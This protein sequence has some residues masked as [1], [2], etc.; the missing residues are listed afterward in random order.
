MCLRKTNFPDIYWKTNAVNRDRGQI[1]LDYGPD[2]FLYQQS[3]KLQVLISNKDLV[4]ELVEENTLGPHNYDQNPFVFN[5]LVAK[6]DY[7]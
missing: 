1:I 7:N 3:G 2:R 4:V 6:K 5:C